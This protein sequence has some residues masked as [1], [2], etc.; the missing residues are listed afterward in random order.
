MNCIDASEYV[1]ALCDGK[2]IPSSMAGHIGNCPD[3]QAK[4]RDYL[5][6]GVELRRIASLE[7]SEPVPS[8]VWT[9]PQT[10]LITWWKKG[11][12]AMRIPRLAFASLI[13]GVVFLASSLA[14]VKARA[15]TSGT[16]VLLNVTGA[17]EKSSRDC[18]LST[19]DKGWQICGREG[20]AGENLYGYIVRLISHKDNRVEL[21]VRVG[22]WP[23]G[24]TKNLEESLK[25]QPERQ[26]WFEPGDTRTIENAGLP[27][28]TIKGTWLDHLPSFPEVDKME[29]ELNELRI[30]SAVL[31][32]DNKVI[33]D[34][35]ARVQQ[36]E[37]DEAAFIV[38]PERGIYL[39]SSSQ[40]QGA[41]EAQVRGN[42]ISFE[43]SGREFVLLAGAPITRSQ[44][45][46]VLHRPDVDS[47]AFGEKKGISLIGAGLKLH[48]TEPGIWVL[49]KPL[50]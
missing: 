34:I 38:I 50:D 33:F 6:I 7:L 21:G 12:S 15:N 46:W 27:T 39:F 5:G 48:Q 40:M 17:N 9:R 22:S 3:C 2:T 4:L 24:S 37:P 11:M 35:G 19:V 41:T 43:E 10:H 25:D 16:V 42:R 20:R 32:E 14:V 8:L 28:L 1:S 36:S 26:F 29:P 23:P 13:V 49:A 30:L 31:L 47:S 45:V 44:S 18:P